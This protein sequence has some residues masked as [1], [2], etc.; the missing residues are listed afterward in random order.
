MELLPDHEASQGFTT[1]CSILDFAVLNTLADSLD[2]ASLLD[3]LKLASTR[4]NDESLLDQ[5]G[6]FSPSLLT[7]IQQTVERR[8]L[9]VHSALK[10][11]L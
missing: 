8:L 1:I 3:V 2:P 10:A 9:A 11:Q 7:K 4:Y 5:I 6:V